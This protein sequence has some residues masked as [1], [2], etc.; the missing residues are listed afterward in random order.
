[1]IT[2]FQFYRNPGQT[3]YDMI[4]LSYPTLRTAIMKQQR[5]PNT[6]NFEQLHFQNLYQHE[7]ALLLQYPSLPAPEDLPHQ[8]KHEDLNTLFDI[9]FQAY[10]FAY[11]IPLPDLDWNEMR[12]MNR[13][14]TWPLILRFMQIHY[15]EHPATGNMSG[16]FSRPY[17]L[18]QASY[19]PQD[20]WGYWTPDEIQQLQ[21]FLQDIVNSTFQDF[22]H[23]CNDVP[24][25][26]PSSD[27][28]SLTPE[29]RHRLARALA[30]YILHALEYLQPHEGLLGYLYVNIEDREQIQSILHCKHPR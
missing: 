15:P 30:E 23:V 19:L 29:E 25:L 7:Q 11:K 24:A 3:L 21:P 4:R 26:P 27:E 2:Q 16:L 5:L 1:M 13:N 6:F 10:R 28:E 18:L 22:V 8:L 17:T 12:A 20:P 14:Q 9:V